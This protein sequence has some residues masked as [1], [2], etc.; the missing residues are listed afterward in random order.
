MPRLH[1]IRNPFLLAGQGLKAGLH[2]IVT[3]IY[4]YRL[5]FST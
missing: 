2:A 5:S 1:S 4:Q 3:P